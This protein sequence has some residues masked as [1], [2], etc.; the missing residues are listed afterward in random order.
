MPFLILRI[1]NNKKTVKTWYG[2]N[3]EDDLNVGEL[4]SRFRSGELDDGLAIDGKYVGCQVVAKFGGN[5]DGD[6][7]MV[8]IETPVSEATCIGKFVTFYVSPINDDISPSSSN[9]RCAFELLMKTASART[10]FPALFSGPTKLD[11][12]KNRIIELFSRYTW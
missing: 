11:L 2:K 1:L 3:I 5:R 8:D 6:G 7:V 12:L 10:S 4:Y 9:K